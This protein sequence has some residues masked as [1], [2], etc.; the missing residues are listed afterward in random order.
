MARGGSGVSDKARA[1][2]NT[3]RWH[4]LRRN[5]EMDIRKNTRMQKLPVER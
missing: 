4:E 3:I 5:G 2:E 1:F